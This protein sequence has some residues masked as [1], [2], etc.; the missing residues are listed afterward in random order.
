MIR[1]G[2]F[3]LNNLFS[4]FNFSGNLEGL[5]EASD[6]GL[7]LSFEG[8]EYRA[9]TF[10]GRLVQEKDAR[11]TK[12]VARRILD[13]MRVD[14]LAVQEV[15]HIEILNEFHERYLNNVYTHVTLIEG[16]R[17]LI[18]VGV[19]SKLP[20]G[21]ITSFQTAHSPPEPLLSL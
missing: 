14:I 17:R 16:D 18:D 5:P 13:V 1:L 10:K 9:R 15:E 2:T 7:P 8:G 21:A 3:N 19:L 12:A 11:D 20:I 6:G 4:R